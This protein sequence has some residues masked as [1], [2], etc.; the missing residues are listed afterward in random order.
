MVD[1]LYVIFVRAYQVTCRLSMFRYKFDILRRHDD[2][3]LLGSSGE[4]DAAHDESHN[5]YQP[6]F[7][8]AFRNFNPTP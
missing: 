7:L 3:G 1:V 4:E 5:P 8:D 2:F 6:P